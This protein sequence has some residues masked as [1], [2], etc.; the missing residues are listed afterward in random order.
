MK[1]LRECFPS[2][3]DL[4]I[5]FLEILDTSTKSFSLLLPIRM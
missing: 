3:F 1:I 5:F 4:N 2:A